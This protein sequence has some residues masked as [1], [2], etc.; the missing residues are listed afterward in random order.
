MSIAASS[1]PRIKRVEVTDEMITAYLVDGR[2]I[3]VPFALSWRRRGPVR[4]GRS[5][6]S[7]RQ[8]LHPR[9]LSELVRV[10]LPLGKLYTRGEA[11][12]AIA[13]A[14]KILEFCR[15]RLS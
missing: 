6:E 8:A 14:Q 11:E 2:I 1:E 10:E 15:R 13:D 9:P 12:G 7:S 4:V 5:R 3:S